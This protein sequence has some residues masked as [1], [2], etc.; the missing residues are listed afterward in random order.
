MGESNPTS[1]KVVHSTS[2]GKSPPPLRPPYKFLFPSHQKSVPPPLN[3][4]FQIIT[5]LSCSHCSCTIFVLISYSFD[6]Q[7]VLILILIDVQYSQN[8]VFSFEKGLNCQNH[9]SSGSHHSLRKFPWQNF[10]SPKLGVNL[11]PSHP[12]PLFGKAWVILFVINCCCTCSLHF[13]N[14]SWVS[15]YSLNLTRLS[16]IADFMIIIEF[17]IL[18]ISKCDLNSVLF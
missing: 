10:R 9:P 6:T 1:Q 3:K 18:T 16:G 14:R 17:R 8:A 12:F 7:V 15:S 13:V 5:Q 2:P 11:R 4:N